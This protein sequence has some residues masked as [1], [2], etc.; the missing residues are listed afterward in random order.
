MKSWIQT[1]PLLA[2]C[3]ACTASELV[4]QAVETA[5]AA[6][7]VRIAPRL[8]ETVDSASP[9]KSAGAAVELLKKQLLQIPE[10]PGGKK[11]K[12]Y[13][14]LAGDPIFAGTPLAGLKLDRPQEYV[15]RFV[16]SSDT[17]NVYAA[18]ADNRGVFYAAATLAQLLTPE[19][20]LLQDIRDYPTWELRYTGG[21]H[22]VPTSF[23]E[24]LARFKINGYGIQHRYDWRRFD[25]EERPIY[26]KK[27]TYRQWF[28]EI[29]QFREK[30]GDL[31]D[32]M[33]MINVYCGKRLDAANPEDIRL[34]IRQCLF[35]AG[36]VQEIMI[37]FDDYTPQENG[38]FVFVS[39][40]EKAQFKN[41]GQVHGRITRLV[42][43][44]LKKDHPNVRISVCP[45]PYSLNSHNAKSASNREYLDSFSRELPKEV[46]IIWTGPAV[47]SPRIT[48]EE[49]REYQKL[50]NGHQLYLWDNSSNMRSAPMGIWET[51]FFPEMSKLDK[52]IYVNGHCFSFLWSWIFA[53]NAN[54]YLWNPSAYDAK[55]SY[56]ACFRAVTGQP[57]PDFV[58]QTRQDLMTAKRTWDRAERG[59]LAKRILDRKN[60]F[61]KHKIDF[62]R[63]ERTVKPIY[64]ECSAEFKTTTVPKLPVVPKL[65]ASGSD[66]A[67]DK[68]VTCRLG[69]TH[70]GST[71]KLGY[72]QQS[73]FIQFKG[74]YGKASEKPLRLPHDSKLD[75]SGDVFYIGLQ[76]PLRNQRAGWIAID[77]D[78]NR[79]DYKEWRPA[80]EF[81]P[82]I[83]QKIQVFAE[84]WILEVEIP[85]KELAEHIM[86][87]PPVSGV[88]WNLNFARRNNLDG[89]ISSWSPAPEKELTAK[90]Y[91]GTVTF[92]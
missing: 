8:F 80:N 31:I 47:E 72:T 1:L 53:V 51:S 46:A 40:A 73:L 14:A 7:T 38:R 55:K 91:F 60:E 85:F 87:R 75:G 43:E 11:L 63:I 90:K 15:L 79:L 74:N 16:E 21:Y 48:A 9:V 32:F 12:L 70:Y 36:Y 20:L 13:L 86:Y 35:A 3:W 89:E 10:A 22:P 84:Y 18:G 5:K 81:N 52:R 49:Y 65:D 92:E 69:S 45:A 17:V 71:V 23:V 37:Q 26:A 30:N 28:E 59:K 83:K 64:D 25:P 6:A 82:Q 77:R 50:V 62:Q 67:W 29:G 24:Q 68:A 66:P 41:P 4:P 54:D 76:P 56:P 27:Q 88:K 44:A 39:D 2:L 58:E 34:L 57:M 19:G 33:M 61:L 42:Y 78:G